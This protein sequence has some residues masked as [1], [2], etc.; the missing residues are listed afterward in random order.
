MKCKG[1]ANLQGIDS[2]YT[3]YFIVMKS[4]ALQISYNMTRYYWTNSSCSNTTVL[5]MEDHYVYHVSSLLHI[6]AV[7]F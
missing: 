5:V 4:I 2:L 3:I 7:F 6:M 1:D